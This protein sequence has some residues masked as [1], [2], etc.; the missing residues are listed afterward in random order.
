MKIAKNPFFGAR[1]GCAV[2]AAS[3]ATLL[4]GPVKAQFLIEN[5]S[6]VKEE[7]FDSLA[8]TG[9]T[10]G[11]TNGSTLL[12]WFL[13]NKDLA[14]ITNYRA[15]NGGSSTGSF[16]SHGATDATE[17]ALGGV[18]SGGAYF[19]S[20]ASGAIAGWM[21]FAATNHSGSL[22]TEFTLAFEGE[23][24]RNGGNTS[25]QTMVF[26]YGFGASFDAVSTWIAPGGGFAWSSPV[27]GATAGP[28]DG[29]TAG[30]V[31]NLGGLIT[32]LNWTNGSTLW[33]RWVEVN[34][35]GNDHG[36]AIDNFS[37]A[38]N[39]F[40]AVPQ[41]WD[42]NGPT[43]GVGGSGVWD[44]TAP[45]WNPLA[46]GTGAPEAYDPNKLPTFSGTPGLVS[47]DDGGVTSNA[48]VRFT[49]P[50][51]TIGGNGTLNLAARP[52]IDVSDSATISAP[53]GGGAGLAKRGAG[54][55][56]LTGANPFT[57]AVDIV[58]GTLEIAA[59]GAL[60]AS[61]NDVRLQGGTFFAN[62]AGASLA[63]GAD[64]SFTGTGTVRVPAGKGMS[65]AGPVNVS[66]VIVTNGSGGT[67]LPIALNFANAS[68]AVSGLTLA[69]PATIDA[70]AG[71]TLGGNV[72]VTHGG[73]TSIHGTIHLGA[74]LRRFE[75][76]DGP[77][78]EDFIL[79]G[80]IASGS[81][82]R[83]HKVGPGTLVLNGANAGLAGGVR[84][85]TTGSTGTTPI[86]PEPGGRLI[87]SSKDGLG[88]AGFQF[89]AG[90]LEATTPLTGPNALAVGISVG[91]GT[92]ENQASP[93]VFAGSPMQFNGTF[94]LFRPAG[95]NAHEMVFNTDVSFN[96][97]FLEPA[98]GIEAEGTSSGLTLSGSGTVRFEGGPV[99]DG[100]E[101][102]KDNLIVVGARVVING[103]TNAN[104]T[105][106]HSG[107]LSGETTY[108]NLTPVTI[109]DSSGIDD[110]VLEPG[111]GIGTM[112]APNFTFRSDAVLRIEIDSTLGTADK[113]RAA[114]VNLGAGIARLEL[115][116][117]SSA[118]LALGTT[119]TIVENTDSVFGQVNGF[120]EGLPD[121][122]PIAAGINFFEVRYGQGAEGL[123]V[124]LV[125]IPEPSTAALAGLALC[126]GLLGRRRS[127][128]A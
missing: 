34:D 44:A 45:R 65:F 114:V 85:G 93:A 11:W 74:A 77:Q 124:T 25:A 9:T 82:G 26:E 55:L 108:T 64:R 15:D 14:A 31:S 116:D 39:S 22:L 24:W 27:V 117:L 13:F 80:T 92:G 37:F 71:L 6:G 94:S 40:T 29:N 53:I 128:R 48:G 86:A 91:G 21:A 126:F 73:Q 30:K 8:N 75:I 54:T 72:I 107:R 125:V 102:F 122:S 61:E 7:D 4:A 32:N 17:R 90:T 79:N 12:G 105:T 88:T 106:V 63:L 78:A 56:A 70:P 41:H 57:G 3:I 28:V 119:L 95:F 84:L 38:W 60:G 19:G 52:T 36:L 96:G 87:I 49:V 127:R 111:D 10:N 23:Q 43:A 42:V 69:S 100:R 50:G 76:P 109:G 16:Y 46:G 97:P 115:A 62:P 113:I 35:V 99:P 89:N 33:L 67:G 58:E 68:S 104:S 103:S 83:L 18:G 118:S 121:G 98:T 47:I 51:Y 66:N 1:T 123:N 81:G 59:D 112:T 101:L 20:P 120:F 5:I 110:A 2:L